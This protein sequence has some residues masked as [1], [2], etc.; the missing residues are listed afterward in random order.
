MAGKFGLT[1]AARTPSSTHVLRQIV[2]ERCDRGFLLLKLSAA[3]DNLESQSWN[4]AILEASFIMNHLM[5]AVDQFQFPG[6]SLPNSYKEAR[7]DR[8]ADLLNGFKR[9]F[10][11]DLHFIR[12][13]EDLVKRG[14]Q[15][16]KERAMRC[17]KIIEETCHAFGIDPSEGDAP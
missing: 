15:A 11:D 6:K 17:V 13:S 3:L 8:N 1:E 2:S 5:E 16:F 4:Y 7:I 14:L 12:Q 9:N 10:T